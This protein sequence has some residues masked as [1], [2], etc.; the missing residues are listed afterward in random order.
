MKSVRDALNKELHINALR[1]KTGRIP[2][3][4]T[5][6]V[7]KHM[8]VFVLKHKVSFSNHLGFIRNSILRCIEND[9]ADILPRINF[10]GF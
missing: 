3:E 10:V 6:L 4:M 7:L 1:I 9:H 8:T 5:I 2:E